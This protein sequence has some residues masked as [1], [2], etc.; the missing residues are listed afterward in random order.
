MSDELTDAGVRAPSRD[1]P[2]DETAIP[3]VG[4]AATEG[5]EAKASARRL[6]SILGIPVIVQ[7]VVGSATLPV[8]SLLKLGRGAVIQLD[9]RVGDFA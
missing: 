1:D 8:S 6:D 3:H 9:H 5:R 2:A 7:A 4:S